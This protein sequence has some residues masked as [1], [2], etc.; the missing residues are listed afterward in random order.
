[1]D[2]TRTRTLIATAVVVPA[3]ALG[4]AACGGSSS[5]STTSGSSTMKT[6]TT[7]PTTSTGTS[8]TPSTA[9]HVALTTGGPNPVAN[10]PWRYTVR[11]SDA[12]GKLVSATVHAQ[13]LSQGT[14]VGQIDNGAVHSAPSGVWTELVTWPPA[15]VGEPLT[16][17]VVVTANG[18]TTSVNYPIS[19]TAS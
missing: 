3:L 13:V 17:Q 11:V 14:V 7:T 5:G 18:T 8:T 4:L 1:M 16:F 9:L 6:A 10:K 15:S 19:V 2:I 12:A